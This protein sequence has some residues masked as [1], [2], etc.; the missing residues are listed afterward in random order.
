MSSFPSPEGEETGAGESWRF[1]RER[2]S[3]ED[4]LATGYTTANGIYYPSEVEQIGEMDYGSKSG[5]SIAL[6]HPG[7]LEPPTRG[8]RVRCSTN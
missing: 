7:G 8:L 5:N 3:Q 4:A 6:V 1:Y 2:R